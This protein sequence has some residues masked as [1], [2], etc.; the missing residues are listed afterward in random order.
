MTV[1]EA[2]AELGG[3]VPWTPEGRLALSDTYLSGNIAE[4][5]AK[6]PRTVE[7]IEPRLKATVQALMNAMPKPLKPGQIKARLGSGW[8]PARY[9][10]EFIEELLPGVTMQATYIP[11]LG[12]W[13]VT[14]KRGFIP[15][16]NSSKYGTRCYTG[17]ELIEAGLNAQTPV[18]YDTVED[19]QGNEK[20]VLN[21]QETVAAQAK[22]EEMKARFDTWLWQDHERAPRNWQRSTTNASTCSSVRTPTARTS[23]C[24]GLANQLTLRPLQKDAVWYSLQRAATLVGDEVAWERP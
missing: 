8:I 17:L 13:T 16:E 6:A 22:L 12:S 24:L 9:I 1:E 2:L 19:E 15:A 5:L 3:R 14:H 4:K 23:R 21:Q 10:S 7:T 20:R 18:V 11:K